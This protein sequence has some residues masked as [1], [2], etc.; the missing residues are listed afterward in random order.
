MIPPLNAAAGQDDAVAVGPVVAPGVAVDLGRPPKFA[1]CDHQG[2]LEQTAAGEIIDQGREGLVGRRNQIV[3]EPAE[4]VLVRVP[5]GC[6]S[7]MLTVVNGDEP[8]AGL[9]QTP[10]Q[11][12][13]LPQLGAAIAVAQLRV[14]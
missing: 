12:N 6:L 14:F 10:G 5:V 1:H 2:F 4:D 13:A 3:L 11:E 9:N 7:V 8:N